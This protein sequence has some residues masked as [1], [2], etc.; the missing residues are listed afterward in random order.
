MIWNSLVEILLNHA[1]ISQPTPQ[2]GQIYK[3]Q[4]FKPGCEM[5]RGVLIAV[6]FTQAE[7]VTGRVCGWEWSQSGW[8]TG[9]SRSCSDFS[10]DFQIWTCMH[11]W[12]LK[13]N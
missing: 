11:V 1:N 3:Y 8:S 10:M 5:D 7:Q 2:R 13:E 12:A 9:A 4:V 6:P